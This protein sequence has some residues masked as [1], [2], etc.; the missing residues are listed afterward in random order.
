MSAA[1][2]SINNTPP[3]SNPQ[4]KGLIESS[5]KHHFSSSVSSV[6][7]LLLSQ[8]LKK[9]INQPLE[10]FG[11]E[12]HVFDLDEGGDGPG[13]DGPGGDGPVDTH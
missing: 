3:K 13:G 4:P 8:L 9:H 7:H 5:D 2:M 11:Q 6:V 1:I 10:P 12:E